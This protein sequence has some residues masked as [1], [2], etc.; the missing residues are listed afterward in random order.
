MS[1]GQASKGRG[2][3]EWQVNQCNGQGKEETWEA[4]LGPTT[5]TAP[6]TGPPLSATNRE[7]DRSSGY[8]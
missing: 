6:A 2:G 5:Y 4:G 7:R 8:V 1:T 3:W